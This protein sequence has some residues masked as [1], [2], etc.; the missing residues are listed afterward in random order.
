MVEGDD[1]EGNDISSAA[2]NALMAMAEISSPG[3]LE[4]VGNFVSNT[5]GHESWQMR[6]AGVLAFNTIL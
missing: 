1:E 3:V 4:L 2:E 6:R 5:I